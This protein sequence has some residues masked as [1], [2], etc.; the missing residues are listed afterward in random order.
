MTAI[1]TLCGGLAVCPERWLLDPQE[2]HSKKEG[3]FVQVDFKGEA[4]Q[5]KEAGKHEWPNHMAAAGSDNQLDP[6]Y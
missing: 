2:A 1:Q 4:T 3:R 6:I 5:A